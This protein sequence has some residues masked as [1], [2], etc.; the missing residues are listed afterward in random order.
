MITLRIRNGIFSCVL[1]CVGSAMVIHDIAISKAVDTHKRVP[2]PIKS[3]LAR[4]HYSI[5]IY[6]KV[7]RDRKG[8]TSKLS[9][10]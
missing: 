2:R 3:K 6:V 5:C 1:Q 10:S 4:L 8:Y 7:N 9:A